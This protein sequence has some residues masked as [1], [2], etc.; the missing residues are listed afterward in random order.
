MEAASIIQHFLNVIGDLARHSRR[1]T[2]STLLG[3]NWWDDIAG[4][5]GQL[6]LP[7]DVLLSVHSME[8]WCSLVSSSRQLVNDSGLVGRSFQPAEPPGSNKPRAL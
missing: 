3:C 1:I 8:G 6:Q 7:A 4:A 2:Q 5:D